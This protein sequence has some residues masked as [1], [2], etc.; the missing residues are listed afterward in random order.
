[1]TNNEMRVIEK[2]RM[3]FVDVTTKPYVHEAARRLKD[4]PRGNWLLVRALNPRP[5][6]AL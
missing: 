3:N 1:M 4:L 2:V 6:K 5:T